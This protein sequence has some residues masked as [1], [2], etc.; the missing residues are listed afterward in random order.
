MKD[1]EKVVI[2]YDKNSESINN[3]VLKIFEKYLETNMPKM[4][5]Q[6]IM[7]AL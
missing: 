1:D 7:D 2:I 5:W 3:K 4:G 6:I